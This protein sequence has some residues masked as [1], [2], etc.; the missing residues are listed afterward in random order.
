MEPCRYSS[1]QRCLSNLKD[2]LRRTQYL[3]KLEGAEIGEEH[4]GKDRKD[5]SRVPTDLLE[6]VFDLNMQLEEMR[7]TRKVGDEDPALEA[8][9]AEAKDKFEGLVVAVDRDLRTEWQLWDAGNES[10]RQ[11]A[12]KRM[13]AL[14]DRRRYLSNL[15][16][17]VTETL[18]LER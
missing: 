14:L 5:P 4:S 13:V 9:L 10:A 12:Q 18:E 2:P 1:T 7:M 17:D 8:S 11:A 16:R 6:E 15:V 3:L